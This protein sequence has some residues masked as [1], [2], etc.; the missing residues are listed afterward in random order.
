MAN[1]K[2]DFIFPNF[3]FIFIFASISQKCFK[4]WVKK[5]FLGFSW[6]LPYNLILIW[7][8]KKSD[9]FSHIFS[10]SFSFLSQLVK[11]SYKVGQIFF[12]RFSWKFP[13]NLILMYKIQ[14]LNL[15]L[16]I[17]SSSS[18]FL[19]WLVK[20]VFKKWVNFFFRFSWKFFISS[21]FLPRKVL[22][23]KFAFTLVIFI[24]WLLWHVFIHFSRKRCI[25]WN[26]LQKRLFPQLFV[27][28]LQYHK[29]TKSYLLFN[30]HGC[31][32]FKLFYISTN[33][34]V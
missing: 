14:K 26:V 7:R 23:C 34:N 1:S 12:L 31:Y 4:R 11:M 8:I 10:S 25:F 9:S 20:D 24:C 30:V 15:F 18:S 2:I 3:F 6:K 22:I 29:I 33:I 21:S 5:I 19:P 17:F 16:H 28:F 27:L 32:C 13:Y